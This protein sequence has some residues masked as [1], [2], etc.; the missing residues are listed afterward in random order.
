[1]VEAY[2]EQAS[3][4]VDGGADLLLIETIFDTLNAKAAI[5]AARDAVRAARPPLA[6]DDLRH[7]HR[8]VRPHPVR[9]GHRG[10][11]EL[12]APRPAAGRRAELRAGR[13]RR[14]V[15]TSPSS[16]RIADCFVSRLPQRR[17]AQ[18][19]RRVR[20]AAR[21][22]RRHRRRVRRA[23]ADQPGRRLLRHHAR[24][25]SPRSPAQRRGARPRVPAEIAPALRLSGLEPLTIDADSLFVNVGERTNITGSARFRN[26]IKDGD[27]DTA[28]SVA[29]QQVE[30]GAQVIDVN[31]DEGMIDG[32][33]AMDRF[34]QA[35]RQRARHQPGAGDGRLLQVGGHRGGPEVRPGQVDRQL[36]LDEGGRAAVP[37][38]TPACAAST[39]PPSS[40]WPSTRTA[41]PTTS[42]AASRSASAPTTSSSTRW[43]SRPRTSS[44]TRTSSRVATGIE[45]HANYGVDFI[46]AARWIKQNLPGAKVSGGISNVSFSFRGNN[47]V[48]EAIHAVFLFHAIKAGLTMG[49]VNAGALVVY[50]EV[51]PELRERIEDVILNRRPDAAERLLEIA[52]QLRRLRPGARGRR[53]GVALAAGRRADHARAGQGHR[54]STSSPTPRS[55]APRSPRAAAA[56]SRSSRAR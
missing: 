17:P 19:L 24:R 44:S 33:A 28:L 9:P 34:L 42:S 20:R 11:L 16:S 32:V 25:T 45:E 47:A 39:A 38:S 51:D 22:H 21:G 12:G 41:R 15:P 2:L 49:I 1:M 35:G 48:R 7:H 27:Y 29:R 6:G 53:R 54:R 23:R 10:V 18:R 8:R 50:D 36:D 5:F 30:N 52:E 40:S 46:E 3:G 13:R 37:S 55:C 56:P 26:L 43:A 14:C 31:M 4:L